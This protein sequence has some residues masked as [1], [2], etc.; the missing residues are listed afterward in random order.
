M[1]YT[2]RIESFLDTE[3]NISTASVN[4]FT[5]EV[6]NRQ[7]AGALAMR[8]ITRAHGLFG[9]YPTF[10]VVGNPKGMEIHITVYL[11]NRAIVHIDAVPKKQTAQSDRKRPRRLH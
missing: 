8:A 4:T 2:I 3:G 11:S 7:E 10:D 1:K 9:H 5:G 6:N